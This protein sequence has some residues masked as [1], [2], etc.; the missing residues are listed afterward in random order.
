[1]KANL[2]LLLSIFIFIK[3]SSLKLTEIRREILA[4]HN[5]RR[6]MHQVG[7]LERDKELEKIAQKYSEKLAADNKGLIH[8]DNGYGENLFYCWSS[9]GICVTG[10][11]ASEEWY[12]EISDY[13]YSNPGFKSGTGHFTQMIWKGSQKI[14]CGAACDSNNKCYVTCNYSPAGNYLSQF[15]EN[16][17]QPKTIEHT[18]E[19]YYE[20][21]GDNFEDDED[22]GN[23][24][25]YLTKSKF[26]SIISI[27]ILL[28]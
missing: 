10:K 1:M 21:E 26:L 13:D 11:Y 3:A 22:E 8:S 9:R 28:I 23:N 5:Y 20:E 17:L 14:G 24:G 4:D 18:Y 19:Y 6:E 25:I 16:V 12:S 2:L 27:L 7:S 15:A